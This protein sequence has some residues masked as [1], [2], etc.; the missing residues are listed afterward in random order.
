MPSNDKAVSCPDV[1][2]EKRYTIPEAAE[3]LS[4]SEKTLYR[5]VGERKVSVYRIG[6]QVR[7]GEHTIARILEDGFIPARRSAA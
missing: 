3:I 1:I 5:W 4:I 6:R 2:R 7:L